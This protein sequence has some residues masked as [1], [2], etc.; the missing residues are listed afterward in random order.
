[1]TMYVNIHYLLLVEA[2]ENSLILFDLI[3]GI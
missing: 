2:V 1:M 3:E